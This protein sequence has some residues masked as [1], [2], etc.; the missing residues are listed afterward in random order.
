MIALDGEAYFIDEFGATLDREMAKV[1]AFCL[2]QVQVGGVQ[3]RT[4]SR[5]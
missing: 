4:R 3:A 5:S 2:Q 1:L